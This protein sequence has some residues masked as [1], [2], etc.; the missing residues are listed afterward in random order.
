MKK[1]IIA[2]FAITL[3]VTSCTEET[4]VPT[5]GNVLFKDSDG[6]Y[7]NELFFIVTETYFLT[8]DN[9]YWYY[10]N[11]DNSIE[12]GTILKEETEVQDLNEGVYFI[13]F[14]GKMKSVMF[15]IKAGQTIEI[16]L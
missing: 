5:T 14:T 13:A 15:Q 16:E 6:K 3:I 8:T 7:L 12:N 4:V 2:L 10:T 11:G 1:I 9:P